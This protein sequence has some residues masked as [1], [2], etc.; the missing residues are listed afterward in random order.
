MRSKNRGWKD[1]SFKVDYD[2]DNSVLSFSSLATDNAYMKAFLTDL[3]LRPSCHSCAVK[4][5]S[6]NSDVTIADYWGVW[7][8]EPEFF[9]NRGTSVVLIHN[10]NLK[11]LFENLNLRYIKSTYEDVV[12]YNSAL[13]R[14]SKPH[15]YRK[16]FWRS[17]KQLKTSQN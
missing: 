8:V 4:E 16:K 2:K 3:I 11:D 12:K 9:D 1:F 10:Q 15:Q 5:C 14:S 6:S 17:L 7:E 13:V